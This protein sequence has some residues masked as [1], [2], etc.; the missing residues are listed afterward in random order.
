MVVAEVA[1]PNAFLT[2]L[3]ADLDDQN[4]ITIALFRVIL[5]FVAGQARQ[6]FVFLWSPGLLAFG[7]LFSLGRFDAIF[8]VED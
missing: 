7:L 6:D 5:R 4:T 2:A 8:R 3:V 1:L